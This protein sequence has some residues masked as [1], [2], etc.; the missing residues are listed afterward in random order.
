MIDEASVMRDSTL[1]T[2]LVSTLPQDRAER[3]LE[4]ATLALANLVRTGTHPHCLS[5]PVNQLLTRVWGI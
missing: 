2:S 3:V 4:A 1:L 5:T